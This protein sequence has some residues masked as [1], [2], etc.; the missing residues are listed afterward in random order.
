[1]AFFDD[2][3]DKVK[4]VLGTD[5]GEQ[6]SD[7]ALNGAA[8]KAGDLTGHKFDSQIEQG[9]QAADDAIGN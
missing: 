3:I 7:Q 6:V 9:E 2:A 4:D 1:M 8:E 5:Q